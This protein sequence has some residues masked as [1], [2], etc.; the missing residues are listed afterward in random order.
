MQKRNLDKM[1]RWKN[2]P[3]N[4]DQEETTNRDWLKTG[5]S[6]TVQKQSEQEFRTTVVRILA[7]L[8]K[9]IE[10][11]REA[12]AA[13]IKDLKTSQAKIKNSIP[14]MQN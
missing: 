6:K 4:K 10:D 2:S 12:P 9:Y 8:E 5:R 11:T 7:G 3:Q 1:T 14:E 13:E